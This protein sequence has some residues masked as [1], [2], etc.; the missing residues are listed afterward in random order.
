MLSADQVPILRTHSTMRCPKRALLTLG[1]T[2]SALRRL[3]SPIRCRFLA[4]V[5]SL[6]C[7]RQ[8]LR[9]L[10]P[11]AAYHHG[12]GHAGDLVGERDSGDFGRPA[13]HQAGEPESF[14]AVLAC[15]SDD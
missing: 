12:P 14:R 5:G 1:T 13:S 3:P 6:C 7:R 11:L 2:L 4:A 8:Q 9:L 10:E 15:I